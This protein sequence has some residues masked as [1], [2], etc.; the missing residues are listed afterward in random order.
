V[1]T[2][3]EFTLADRLGA[4]GFS[5]IVKVRNKILEMRARGE[6]VFQFEG[7]EPFPNTPDYVKAACMRALEENRTRYAPSSGITPLIDAVAEKLNRTNRIPADGSEVIVVAGGMHALFGAF[8]SVLN[9]GDQV[10][11]FSPYWT[12]IRD[13]VRLARAEIALVDTRAARAADFRGAVEAAVTPRTRC[14]YLNSPQNPTGYVFTRAELEAIADVA[15]ERNLIVISDEAYEDITYETEHV[16][17]ASLP[18]MYERTISCFTFSKSYAMT[19]WRL[20][21]AAAPEPFITGM[22]KLTLTTTNGV[23]TPTQWAGVAA[24]RTESDFVAANRAAY[25]ERRDLLVAGLCELGFEC[26]EPHGA[27]YAFPRAD[28]FGEDSW[29]IADEL[30]AR[31]RVACLPGVIFGPHGEGHLR[32]SYSTSVEIIERGLE[33]LRGVLT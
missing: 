33:A 6:E 32:F 30:L 29:K 17:I 4:V 22:K 7:G 1:S 15:R 25:R 3:T 31:A 8:Q 26:E 10:V 5:E 24:L 11:V 13:L 19:G 14:I 2:Q 21:Y 16:S 28:R 12:P 23:S 27:F 9:M 20:G 18:D